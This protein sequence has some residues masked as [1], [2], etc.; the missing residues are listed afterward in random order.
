M[1]E[2]L[3]RELAAVGIRAR[4]RDRILAEFEVD[5]IFH[6]AALLSTRSEFTPV[7]AHHVNV[8][9]T[10]N[11]LEFAQKQ[12]ESHG[13]SVVFIYPS[14]IAAYG[15]PDLETKNRA[16]SVREDTYAQPMTMRGFL[17]RFNSCSFI[18]ILDDRSKKEVL[19]KLSDLVRT[20]PDLAGNERLEQPYVTEVYVYGPN[21]RVMGEVE[22]IGPSTRRSLVVDLPGGDYEVACKP[23]MTGDGIRTPIH[24][25]GSASTS[26]SATRFASS[27][28]RRSHRSSTSTS[29]SENF[30]S[31]S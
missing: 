12:G 15:L 8:E 27:W 20:H 28:P 22:N 21:N 2:E 19:S 31:T 13:R 14:S 5:R 30:P 1:I 4:Q 16:G 3:G 10:L 25:S 7:A 29:A 11:L 26:S 17:D 23:G 24:V 18:A 6:L 9:G